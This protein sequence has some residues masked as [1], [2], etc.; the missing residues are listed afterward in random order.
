ML[1]KEVDPAEHSKITFSQ[2]VSAL[3]NELI[4]MSTSY[5]STA[6]TP[7]SRDTVS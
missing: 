1:L 4:D 2:S 3:S 7:I 6:E 5:T